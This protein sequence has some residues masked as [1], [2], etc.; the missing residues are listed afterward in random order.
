ML[1]ISNLI[2][3]FIITCVQIFL[4]SGDFLPEIDQN[5]VDN[6]YVTGSLLATSKIIHVS[7]T[8]KIECIYHQ[9][10]KKKNK[11]C[12]VILLKRLDHAI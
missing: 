4:I 12:V 5:Y 6:N 2:L 9:K 10:K 8:S 7:T 1:K 3:Y 11:K